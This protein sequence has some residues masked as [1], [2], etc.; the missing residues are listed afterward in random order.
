MLSNTD[1]K[2]SEMISKFNHYENEYV[3][4]EID[5]DKKDDIVEKVKD[6]AKEQDYKYL[7]IDGIRVEFDDGFALI[8]GSNTQPILTIR[9]EATTKDRL[10]EIRAEFMNLINSVVDSL[11]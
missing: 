1:L 11:N 2:L 8:R 6:Y 10:D 7:D 3:E 5:I 9:F 4:Y